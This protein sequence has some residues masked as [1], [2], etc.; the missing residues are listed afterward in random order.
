MF[1]STW[2]RI[3]GNRSRTAL[4]DSTSWPGLDLELDAAIALGE[5]A[6]DDFDELGRIL[7]DADRDSAVDLGAHRS[8]MV[9]ER[10]AGGSQLGIEDG[11]LER[12]LRHGMTVDRA[13][14]LP[15]LVGGDVAR[16]EEPR[17]QVTAD[18]VLGAVHVLG[19]V[20]RPGHR[21]A[22]APT[23]GIAGDDAHEEDVAVVLD[24]EGHPEGGD[25]RDADPAEV[26]CLDLHRLRRSQPSR[27]IASPRYPFATALPTATRT[28]S[29]HASA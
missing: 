20:E 2:S 13:E 8:E 22:F 29:R 7:V 1:A 19:R 9:A 6:A 18:D 17:Q 16:L 15:D 10:D 21:H 25:H 27:V 3:S 26:D 14:D 28:A 5:V 24:A 11:H 23:L 4:T 12:R